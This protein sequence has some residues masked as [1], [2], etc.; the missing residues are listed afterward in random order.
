MS[1]P[2]IRDGVNLPVFARRRRVAGLQ[3][4]TLLEVLVGFTLLSTIL[5]PIGMF[6]I[7][8]LRGSSELGN[9]HQAISLVEEKME[10]ALTQPF[11]AL[12]LGVTENK[13]LVLN[14]KET[15]DLRPVELGPE[16]VRLIMTV[17]ALPVEF[18]AISDI[19]SGKVE[20]VRVDDGM[21]KI[22]LRA[23]WGRKSEHFFDLIAYKAN[24]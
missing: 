3:G 17:E 14:G 1:E 5:L 8:F 15:I 18:S 21:K 22:T 9:S 19:A 6:L 12:P 24:L 13:R 2:E 7:E 4:V 16:T 10:S 23:T 20:R 11:E